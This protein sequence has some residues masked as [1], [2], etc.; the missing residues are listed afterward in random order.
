MSLY[1]VQKLLYNLNREPGLKQSFDLDQDNVMNN[2]VLSEE[3]TQAL[4]KPDIG[5][6][7][8]LGVNGQLL[9]HYATMNG[10]SWSD[11]IQAMRDGVEYYGPVRE[12]LYAMI[13]GDGAT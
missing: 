12:G 3:E 6:L 7:Y 9:M 11:Y 4:K 5:L 13:D 8:V 2:Y 10:Y 1:Y